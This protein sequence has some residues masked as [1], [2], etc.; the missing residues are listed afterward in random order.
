MGPLEDP[1]D[2]QRWQKV[3]SFPATPTQHLSF[4]GGRWGEGGLL[5]ILSTFLT[6]EE[7]TFL[8]GQREMEEAG[9]GMW[10]P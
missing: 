1:P 2:P 4:G 6:G 5:L 3:A 8:T 10:C 7:R 9:Q